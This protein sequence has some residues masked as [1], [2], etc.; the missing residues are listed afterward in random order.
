MYSVYDYLATA[1]VYSAK[2]ALLISLNSTI[3]FYISSMDE[4]LFELIENSN[5]YPTMTKLNNYSHNSFL[6][7]TFRWNILLQNQITIEHHVFFLTKGFSLTLST[8]SKGYAAIY[9]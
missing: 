2:L 5:I 4:I 7:N 8:I 9:F 1:V 3:F 6:D